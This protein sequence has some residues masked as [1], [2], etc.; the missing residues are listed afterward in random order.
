MGAR[1]FLCCFSAAIVRAFFALVED[2][3][4]KARGLLPLAWESPFFFFSFAFFFFALAPARGRG[5][6]CS[7][8]PL[9][10][11]P[12]IPRVVRSRE[13]CRHRAR[14]H[15][16]ALARPVETSA[17]EVCRRRG[18]AGWT[19]RRLRRR[20]RCPAEIM[21]GRSA[22]AKTRGARTAIF[23]ID[24]PLVPLTSSPP[25]AGTHARAPLESLRL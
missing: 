21:R 22:R 24:Q 6:P 4:M 19:W 5:A 17:R 8:V 3:K 14:F 16:D 11:S 23:R 20:P 13:L 15:S 12:M 10:S 25:C 7:A 1:S 18:I 9:P 2:L